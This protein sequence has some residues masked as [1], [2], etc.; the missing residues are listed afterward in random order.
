MLRA[1]HLGLPLLVG[2][3]SALAEAALFLAMVCF[4]WP[5]HG[6]TSGPV[7]HLA[8]S[9]PLCMLMGHCVE[10]SPSLVVK[11]GIDQHIRLLES[12]PPSLG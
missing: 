2:S 3:A 10:F 12:I 1:L 11:G 9:G 4:A 5:T 8:H 7:W 6:V